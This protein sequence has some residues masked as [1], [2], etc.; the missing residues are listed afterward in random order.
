MSS[1]SD[2]KSGSPDKK[3]VIRQAMLGGPIL[4]TLLRLALPTIVVLIAQTAVGV[5]ETYYVSFLGT[6][7]IVGVALVF[8]IWMLMAMMS[9][10]GIGGGVAAA[11]ARAAGAG[12]HE[13]AT[14]LVW[15]ALVLAILFGSAFTGL[16][17]LF[18]AELYRSLGA[19]E[20]SLASALLYSGYIFLAAIPI[21]I[22][23]LMSAALRGIG[24]VRI[25]ALVTLGGAIVLIPLSPAFIF[26]VGP[27]PGLG[28]AGAGI[29]VTLYYLGAAAYLVQYL[30]KGKSGLQL[31]FSRLRWRHFK[32]TLGV[33]SISALSTVQLNLTVILVT[34]AVGRFGN[35]ALAG[36]G[37]AARLDYVVIPMLFGFG[38]AM[39]TMVGTNVGAGNLARAKRIVW[40]GTGVGAG[41][42]E[43]I[44]LSAA[45]FPEAWI[46]IF[47]HDAAVLAAGAA[48][49]RVVGPFY[50]AVGLAFLLSFASQGSGRPFWP[51]FGGTARLLIS[52]GLGWVL[53]AIFAASITALFGASAFGAVVAAAICALATLTGATFRAELPFAG[54]TSARAIRRQGASGEEGSSIISVSTASL[55]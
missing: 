19:D 17:L 3:A 49:L 29:A 47:S 50:G 21:W 18:G 48:Y 5:A 7:A 13:D 28:L 12:R 53:V 55:P 31:R 9:A 44:G 25:P 26:G 1:I 33:G 45:L 40:I 24:N 43:V 27:A 42:M 38:T 46:G 39:L 54:D 34:G 51:F 37:M 15:H 16:V 14:A 4:P 36:Y 20:S 35:E 11:V 10:G 2:R 30:A 52:A 32:A 22:V 23:N 41:I 8:P 6:Q